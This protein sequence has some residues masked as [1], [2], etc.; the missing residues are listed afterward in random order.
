MIGAASGSELL[1]VIE[2]PESWVQN[3]Q[4]V[5]QSKNERR[6]RTRRRRH[7]CREHTQEVAGGRRGR[8][9]PIR[10]QQLEMRCVR[11]RR[12]V[13][14]PIR[15]E[16]GR[17]TRHAEPSQ[18]A[19]RV[20]HQRA[21]AGGGPLRELLRGKGSVARGGL[22]GVRR[23][24]EEREEEERVVR[25][26]LPDGGEVLQRGD[27]QSGERLGVADAGVEEDGGGADAAGREDNLVGRG[28]GE[29]LC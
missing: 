17:V 21:G 1:M 8:D 11:S 4:Y 3:E 22:E 20:V 14:S 13:V 2:P 7:H 12:R 6:E 29:T 27:T 15:T 16:H 5:F 10:N 26:V 28:E 24:D 9:H 18:V 19:D 25:E 23:V